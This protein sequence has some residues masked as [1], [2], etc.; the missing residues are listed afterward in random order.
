MVV[1]WFVLSTA[2]CKFYFNSRYDFWNPTEHKY[3]QY[4]RIRNIFVH[5]TQYR[6]SNIYTFLK[7][8]LIYLL[9]KMESKFF[10][11]IQHNINECLRVYKFGKRPMKLNS[12]LFIF[13]YIPS[14]FPYF[15]FIFQI[16]SNVFSVSIGLFFFICAIQVSSFLKWRVFTLSVMLSCWFS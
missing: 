4:F 3:L 16:F 2:M 11:K 8:A 10:T 5:G 1:V 7:V 13:F 12:Y 15:R 14:H 6:P 9:V